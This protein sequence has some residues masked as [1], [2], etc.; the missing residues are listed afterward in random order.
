METSGPNFESQHIEEVGVLCEK[1]V[2][3]SAVIVN[4]SHQNSQKIHTNQVAVE[5]T[6]VSDHVNGTSEQLREIMVESK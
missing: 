2:V 3:D 5:H 6:L 4:C 1:S